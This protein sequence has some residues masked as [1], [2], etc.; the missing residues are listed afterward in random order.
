MSILRRN[1]LQLCCIVFAAWIGMGAAQAATEQE[2]TTFF[3]SVKL[4]E[5]GTARKMLAAGTVGPNAIDP[6]SGESALIVALRE[7]SSHV[8]ELLLAQPGLKLELNAPNGNTA[9]MMAAFK[10]NKPAV[11]ALLAKGAIVNRPGYT[12]LHFAAAAGD[13]EIT[14]ILLEHHAYIDAEAPAKYTPLMMA[15]REGQESTV[16]VLLEAGAD[17]TLKN[18]ESLT[19]AQIAARADKPLIVA[20][21]TAHLAARK[22]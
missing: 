22:Q 7:G 6:I 12:A 5:P 4:D 11:L 10:H 14:R 15:A 2:L 17:A 18:T 3:R 9:L 1:V 8:I 20:A 16:K 13:D 21:I 19:A